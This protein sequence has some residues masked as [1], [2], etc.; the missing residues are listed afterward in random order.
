VA[1]SSW[2]A[3]EAMS[4]LWRL[5]SGVAVEWTDPA[6]PSGVTVPEPGETGGTATVNLNVTNGE[7]TLDCLFARYGAPP[8]ERLTQITECYPPAEDRSVFGCTV[9][10][11]NALPRGEMG[12]TFTAHV[13]SRVYGFSGG[14][15]L[16][17]S[18]LALMQLHSPTN[19]DDTARFMAE[20]VERRFGDVVR[21]LHAAGV[22][23]EVGGPMLESVWADVHPRV[24]AEAEARLLHGGPWAEIHPGNYRDQPWTWLD[25]QSGSERANGR[26]ER[27][28]LD[29]LNPAQREEF[30]RSGN[31]RFSVELTIDCNNERH[32]A[33]LAPRGRYVISRSHIY[34][35]RG[36]DGARY[37]LQV[38][39]A[40]LCD[41]L[42]A[43]KLLLE[44]DPQRFF[45]VANRQPPPP[46][47]YAGTPRLAGLSAN[48]M[49]AALGLPPAP[50]P[51][52]R[53]P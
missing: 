8:P 39:G 52:R 17:V 35:V 36:P 19:F 49:R 28:L 20:E 47:S 41:T 14:T 32:H 53:S 4:D 31:V 33:P 2:S 44:T 37:C 34:N 25:G 16:V 51:T 48:E 23:Q 18:P 29:S 26:A 27:L 9:T 10:R 1:N 24:C 7:S 43:Q 3:F 30:V 38:P 15:E 50:P 46:P 6:P 22:S 45:A 40:P 13:D 11:H 5:S 21:A 42:L 12:M